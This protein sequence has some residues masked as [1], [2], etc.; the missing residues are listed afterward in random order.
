ME[1][2]P[3]QVTL[4]LCG[5]DGEV[6][7]ALPP[8]EVEL[9]WW[10]E[11]GPVVA[12]VRDRHGIDVVVLRL[13]TA[14]RDEPHG[15]AVT[16]LAELA[17]PPPDGLL[18][19]AG[20]PGDDPKRL[21]WAAPGGPAADVAWADATL[22]ALGRPRC[23]P[24]VQVRTWNLSSLWRLPTAAGDT[25]L[26]VVPPFFAHEGDVIGRLDPAVAPPLLA[27]DRPRILLDAIGGE[28]LYDATLPQLLLMVRTLVDLQA[29]WTGRTGE[30]LA[31][32][33]PDWRPAEL[34]A[35]AADVLERHAHEVGSGTAAGVAALLD[36]WDQRWGALAACGIPDSL[37]HG[38]F[39]PGNV[40]GEGDHITLLD[41]GD[42]GVGHPLLDQA[43]FT[44]QLDP[45]PAAAVRAAWADAWAQA[46]PGSDASRAAEL[47]AP[48]AA[49][50][51]AVIYRSFLDQIEASEQVYH[52]ADPASW[53]VRAVESAGGSGR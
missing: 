19:W 35:A 36:R 40:R 28:D 49:L 14:E 32:G 43:A 6:L 51:Q 42:C 23:G 15:G 39:H 38:D 24:A 41:W 7:G 4:V 45:E 47:L 18:P 53:L 12:T 16:Y 8:F 20:A 27:A 22:A 3:R 34:A 52:R 9:P 50:R 17:S 10:Q 33:A 25:W 29:G 11:V 5:S 46:V 2:G 21:P 44:W 37:V 48:V 13:L 1:F 26:K 30:L 31:L